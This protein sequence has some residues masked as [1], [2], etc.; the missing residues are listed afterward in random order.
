MREE[1]RSAIYDQSE[2]RS[3]GKMYKLLQKGSLGNTFRTWGSWSEVLK[4][5]YRGIVSVRSKSIADP[6]RMYDVPF[7]VVAASMENKLKGKDVVILEATP[8]STRRI[9]GELRDLPGGMYFRYT[10]ARLPM[11]VAFDV[12]DRLATGVQANIL[13]REYV[14]P[15]SYDDIL[16][17][18]NMYPGCVIE[19]TTFSVNVGTLGRPT[20]IW[21][22]RHY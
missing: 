18:F 10:L 8:H 22:V 2:I 17:L 11:R 19:F 1:H 21:E 16:E 9:Q 6:I 15:S 4:S 3:K 14:D 13:L 7:E 5:G 12:D 20:V